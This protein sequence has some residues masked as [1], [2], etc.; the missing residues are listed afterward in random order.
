MNDSTLDAR[1]PAAEVLNE[2]TTD[3]IEGPIMGYGKCSISGCPCAGYQQTY[4]SDLC[5]NCGHRY[6]DH[7]QGS[8]AEGNSARETATTMPQQ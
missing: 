7:W 2:E 6:T 4:G 1:R 3:R 5:S 8:S